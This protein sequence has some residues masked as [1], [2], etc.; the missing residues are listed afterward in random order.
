[1]PLNQDDRIKGV[2]ASVDKR[3]QNRIERNRQA[4]YLYHVD[5][6]RV[7]VIAFRLGLT[8]AKV[9]EYLKTPVDNTPQPNQWKHETLKETEN[10]LL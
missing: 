2:R 10:E 7:E 8:S 5:G 1:M 6:L 9:R 4:N 3:K